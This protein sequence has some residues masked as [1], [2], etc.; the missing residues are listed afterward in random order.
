METRLD[1]AAMSASVARL[2]KN[3]RFAEVAKRFPEP[4]LTHSHN[5]FRALAR[6]IIHQ[7]LST[8]AA[9]TIEG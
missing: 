5:A 2:N 7:Q 1:S 9:A 3:K 8:K 6:A 4:V